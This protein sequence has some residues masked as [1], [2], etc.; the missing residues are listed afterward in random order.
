M[1]A[2]E[3]FG[4]NRHVYDIPPQMFESKIYT[5][6]GYS[7]IDNDEQTQLKSASLQNSS[8][9]SPR[10]LCASLC[11]RSIIALFTT[12]ERKHFG[13]RWVSRYILSCCFSLGLSC[14]I[15]LSACESNHSYLHNKDQEL[16][17][18]KTRSIIL[19]ISTSPHQEMLE[20][21]IL[22]ICSIGHQLFHWLDN[23]LPAN[24]F[25][26]QIEYA[27]SS[28]NWSLV[29]VLSWICRPHRLGST[30]ILLLDF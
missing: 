4:W 18:A 17:I 7:E 16:I 5:I 23:Y 1:L 21:R 20:W 28:P 8:S 27:D 14:W 6:L 30:L 24:P 19:A 15:C 12:P 25:S 2:I 29:S 26:P 13:A 11:F 9:S 10:L 22:W 3:V